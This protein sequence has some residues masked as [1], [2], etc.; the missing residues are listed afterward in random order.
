MN[1][2]TPPAKKITLEEITER[3]RMLLDEIRAQKTVMAHTAREIFA[4]LT[5][6]ASKTNALM[7][8]FDTGMAIFDGVMLGVKFM[9]KVRSY[10]RR[11]K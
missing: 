7:R 10:F 11:I 8:S 1:A 4:P 9:R 5:T 2:Q 6:A 3:K